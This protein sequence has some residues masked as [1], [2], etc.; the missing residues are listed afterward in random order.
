MIELRREVPD[1][2]LRQGFVPAERYGI[3]NSENMYA[4]VLQAC[5]LYGGVLKGRR[6][7]I[8]RMKYTM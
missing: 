5:E 3:R 1:Y 7:V 6:D 4:D 2:Y 8:M